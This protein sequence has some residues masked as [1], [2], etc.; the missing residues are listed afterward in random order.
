MSSKGEQTLTSKY[1]LKFTKE[2]ILPEVK[3]I[4]DE[5]NIQYRD[6]IL[7]SNDKLSVKLDKILAE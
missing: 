6:E 3:K 1:L 2:Y 7:T 4:V 5:S